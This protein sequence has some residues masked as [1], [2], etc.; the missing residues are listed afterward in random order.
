MF[1]LSASIGVA[2]VDGQTSA[3]ELLRCADSAVSAAK[4][5]GR[6]RVEIFDA[7]L[8]A[9]IKHDAEL[10]LALRQAILNDEL[11]LHLQPITDLHTGRPSGAEALVRWE[12]PGH[13][14]VPPSSFIFIAE[15]S[16]SSSTE[17]R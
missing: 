2:V 12:R 11:V 16:P 9:S 7:E 5:R 4:R 13:G 15:R 3:N 6:S 17:S 8:Q 1:A 10:E 14:M